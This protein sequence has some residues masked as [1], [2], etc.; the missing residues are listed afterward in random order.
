[1]VGKGAKPPSQGLSLDR[2]RWQQE[3]KKQFIV[4][5][6]DSLNKI[7]RITSIP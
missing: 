7:A 1:V 3:E 2:E 4:R 5:K 6:G